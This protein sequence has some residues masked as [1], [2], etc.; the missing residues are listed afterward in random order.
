MYRLGKRT[1]L[2]LRGNAA[3]A[4]VAA[5]KLQSACSLHELEHG[6]EMPARALSRY[7]RHVLSRG[8]IDALIASCA[9]ERPDEPTEATVKGELYWIHRSGLWYPVDY[10][11]HGEE[12]RMLWSLLDRR[13]SKHL[14]YKEALQLVQ[15]CWEAVRTR[16]PHNLPGVKTV[17]VD[18]RGYRELDVVAELERRKNHGS[19]ALEAA[20]AG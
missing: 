11:A 20:A 16:S 10:A 1:V 3:D 7:G 17:L 6:C 12:G 4:R 13:Y 19:E 9:C 8:S 5:S 18:E 14:S 15:D 2:G